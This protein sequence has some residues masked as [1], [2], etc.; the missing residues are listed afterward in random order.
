M[1]KQ[2]PSLPFQQKQGISCQIHLRVLS[3]SVPLCSKKANAGRN[4]KQ[5]KEYSEKEKEDEFRRIRLEW[6]RKKDGQRRKKKTLG[7]KEGGR[8]GREKKE[9]GEEEYVGCYLCLKKKQKK[10][11][12]EVM[13]AL[14]YC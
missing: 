1:H 13:I 4:A 5:N 2:Q 11:Q 9:E 3:N 6:E 14:E 10:K 12:I 8:G 7:D